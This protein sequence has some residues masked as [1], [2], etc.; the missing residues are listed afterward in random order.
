MFFS[1][2]AV[3]LILGVSA[4]LRPRRRYPGKS[5]T[6]YECGEEPVGTAWAQFNIRFY[7]IAIVFIIFDVEVAA[8][9]PCIVIFRESI[10]NGLG[11]L[12]FAEVFVFIGLLVAGLIYCWVRGD[13]EW[14]KTLSRT[15]EGKRRVS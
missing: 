14:V 1:I 10:S 13:L 6:P 4:L 3:P 15:V 2:I 12:V 7:V 9:F 11:W 5:G 8:L